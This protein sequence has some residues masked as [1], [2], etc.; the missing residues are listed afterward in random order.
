MGLYRGLWDYCRVFREI[1]GVEIIAHTGYMD[2]RL[3]SY[4]GVYKGILENQFGCF[5]KP[6]SFRGCR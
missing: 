6:W 4:I 3:Y 5:L 2:G 1:P